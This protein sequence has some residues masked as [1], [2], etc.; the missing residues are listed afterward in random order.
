MTFSPDNLRETFGTTLLELGEDYDNLLV[1]DADLN[2]STRAVYFKKRFPDRFFQCGI[3]EGNM[4]ALAAGLAAT[5]HITIPITFAAFATRKALDQIVMNVCAERANVKI[6]GSYVGMTATECGPSHNLVEDLAVMRSLPH[7][8]VA[9]P[10]DH[11]ELASVMRVAVETDG[12]VYFRVPKVEPAVLFEGNH[13]FQ[14]GK[15]HRLREGSDISLVGTGMMTPILV[16]AAEM[17][18]GRGINAEVIHMA[19]VKPIDTEMLA[20]T[21]SRT[22]RVLTLENGRIFGGF[23]GAVAEALAQTHPCPMTMMGIGDVEVESAPLED[24]L[25]HYELT[26]RDVADRAAVFC[27]ADVKAGRAQ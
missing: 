7:M 2:T 1:L 10:G 13:Q 26:P 3:A 23:G 9:A 22:G 17:L 20:D 15:G 6:P 19:S 16:A 8:K 4:M 5:G 18:D 27:Q 11:A 24:L 14:W 25:R 12:P 21:A